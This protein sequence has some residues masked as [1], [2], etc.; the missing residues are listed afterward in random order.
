M[1]RHRT[2]PIAVSGD[3]D[4]RRQLDSSC[5]LSGPRR[6]SGRGGAGTR[7]RGRRGYG[8]LED[9]AHRPARRRARRAGST[10]AWASPAADRRAG[11]AAPSASDA[12]VARSAKSRATQGK[13]IDHS[14]G[15]AARPDLWR[16]D[17]ATGDCE[18]YALAKRARLLRGRPAGRRGAPCHR[19]PALRRA[20]R[21]AHGR[22]RPRH[23]RAGQSAAGRRPACGH[24]A[25]LGIASRG[26]RGPRCAGASSPGAMDAPDEPRPPTARPR[27]PSSMM[28]RRRDCVTA[29]RPS[30]SSRQLPPARRQRWRHHG[31]ACSPASRAAADGGGRRPMP[32]IEAPSS[33]PGSAEFG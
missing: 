3:G 4:V 13:R 18:D 2:R 28:S 21:R 6:R 31:R 25:T 23:A 7:S 32:A 33:L 29:R 27:I 11:R 12:G 5:L 24:C 17:A 15:R 19:A 16:A 22:D 10:G 8:R 30:Y 20:A 1:Q 26:P 14:R 9:L